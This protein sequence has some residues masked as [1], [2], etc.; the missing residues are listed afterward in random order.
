MADI[1]FSCQNCGSHLE[2]EGTGAGSTVSCPNCN[3]ELRVPEQE[4]IHDPALKVSTTFLESST[5]QDISKNN[6]STPSTTQCRGYFNREY[7]KSGN[8]ITCP[9]CGKSFEVAIGIS[10]AVHCPYCQ[11]SVEPISARQRTARDGDGQEEKIGFIGIIFG[12]IALVPTAIGLFFVVWVMPAVWDWGTNNV[13][14]AVGSIEEHLT[15]TQ[16]KQASPSPQPPAPSPPTQQPQHS[17]AWE[18]GYCRDSQGG[19]PRTQSFVSVAP[20]AEIRRRGHDQVDRTRGDLTHEDHGITGDDAVD[21]R[22]LACARC[23]LLLHDCL[24]ASGSDAM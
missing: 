17:Q 4:A 9:D 13:S 7:F 6:V 24:R 12:I 16:A 19:D 20:R 2:I 1:K 15:T 18:D 5:I 10:R 3:A 21:Q 23:I 8:G 11:A 22:R 14:R